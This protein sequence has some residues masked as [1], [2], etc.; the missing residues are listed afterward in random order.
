LDIIQPASAGFLVYEPV[1]R[2]LGTGIN[3]RRPHSITSSLRFEIHGYLEL[4]VK[5]RLVPQKLVYQA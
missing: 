2:V 5:P 4:L 1:V 3:H